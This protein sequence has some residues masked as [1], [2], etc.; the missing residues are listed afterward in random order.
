LTKKKAEF[1]HHV[2]PAHTVF[3]YVIGGKGITGGTE[4][5]NGDLVLFGKG[6]R[7][8]VSAPD[9]AVRLLLLSGRPLFC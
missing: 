5:E 2:D 3:I 4:I 9:E 8:T 1:S 6:P 7:V